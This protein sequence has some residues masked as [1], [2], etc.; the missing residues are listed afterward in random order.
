[1]KE[2]IEH[3]V[4]SIVDFPESVDVRQIDGESTIVFE[5]RVRQDDVGK[6]IGK[7]GRTINAIRTLVNA[8]AAKSSMRAM[9]EIVEENKQ[10][11]PEE[12]KQSSL[13]EDKQSSL[14]E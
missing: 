5:L 10:S 3:I 2:L 12:D 8:T 11:S 13:E 7:K 1:M 4:K 14:E 6:V 9:L